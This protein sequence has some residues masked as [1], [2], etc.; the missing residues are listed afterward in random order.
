MEYRE[1]GQT[2]LVSSEV[3][4]GVIPLSPN[5]ANLGPE[6]GSALIKYALDS[7][8]N[9]IDAAESYRVVPVLERL[10]KDYGNDFLLSYKS[11]AAT[12]EDMSAAID[13]VLKAMKRE[14]LD[15][16]YLHAAKEPAMFTKRAGALECLIDY[17]KKG[18]VR[19]IGVS[20][21]IVSL[22]REAAV[23]KD[24]DLVFSIVNIIGQ[25]LIGGTQEEMLEAMELA[26]QNNKGVIAMKALAGGNLMNRVPEALAFVREIP[27]L[28]ATA[29]GMVS[30][31][32]IDINLRIFAGEE[33]SEEELAPLR[34]PKRVIIN[35]QCKGCGE[36]VIAC[37]SDAL[38]MENNRPVVIAEKC[39]VCGYCNPVCVH[40][41]LRIV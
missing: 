39:L 38:Y 32:E 8:I 40:F 15:I 21:H 23:H 36:C 18:K 22:I 27:W 29:L 26:H 25:G 10:A 13:L 12:Y 20:S 9:H 19:A 41:A 5:Q 4:F 7:G 28:S 14:A 17:K 24:V 11:H 2:G 35:R 31:A 34:N 30:E 6:K 1:I 3:I 33:V 37:P 16:M